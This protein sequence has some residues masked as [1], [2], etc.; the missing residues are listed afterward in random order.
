MT[1]TRSN[2]GPIVVK[3]GVLASVLKVILL[4]TGFPCGQRSRLDLKSD[5]TVAE[6]QSVEAYFHSF[7]IRDKAS[8]QWQG[9]S[10]SRLKIACLTWSLERTKWQK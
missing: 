3:N 4:K 2:T 10:M 1:V 5:H 7:G 6:G 9:S 8:R